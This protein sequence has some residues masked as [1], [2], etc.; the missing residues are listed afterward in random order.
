MKIEYRGSIGNVAT[1]T[2][3]RKFSELKF[4]IVEGI[5]LFSCLTLS[6]RIFAINKD[7]FRFMSGIRPSDHR[8]AYRSSLNELKNKAFI[9]IIIMFKTA[10][11]HSTH[12]KR[13]TAAYSI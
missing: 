5:Y 1:Q 4:G 2:L 13:F 8:V 9:Y 11:L 10:L 7:I 12:M 3:L 6:T